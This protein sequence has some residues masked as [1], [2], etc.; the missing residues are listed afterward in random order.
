[1]SVWSTVTLTQIAF[2]NPTEKLTKGKFVTKISMDNLR[3]YSK[4][5]YSQSQEAYNGGMKFRNGDTLV[6][7][8]TPCLENGK[9]AFVDTLDSNEV[10]FG[11]TEYIVLRAKKDLSDSHFLEPIQY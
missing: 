8:I 5:I 3:P 7:R 1:M 10:G 6:A 9:T 4:K 2:V 11:S